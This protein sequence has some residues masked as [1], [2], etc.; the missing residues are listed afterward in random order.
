MPW[1]GG[2]PGLR[3]FSRTRSRRA[4]LAFGV[5]KRPP[6]AIFCLWLGLCGGAHAANQDPLD[7]ESPP[8]FSDG[9]LAACRARDYQRA[10][11][12]LDLRKFPA[13][14]RL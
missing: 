14:R 10:W 5:R 6:T 2:P 3:G 1:W 4:K 9:F 8:E 7:R 11:R 12:Y 13:S